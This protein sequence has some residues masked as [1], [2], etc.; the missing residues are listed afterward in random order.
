MD[1]KTYTLIS[2]L[3]TKEQKNKLDKICG[4][5]GMSKFIRQAVENHV[6]LTTKLRS[7]S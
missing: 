6:K 4:K 5:Q 2:Y 3:E 7:R 1:K